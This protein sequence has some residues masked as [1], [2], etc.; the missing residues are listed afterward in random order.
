MVLP[1]D[2]VVDLKDV[3][4]DDKHHVGDRAANLGSLACK[5]SVPQGFIVAYPAYFEFLSHDNLG[6]KIKHL[7]GAINFDFPESVGHVSSHIRRII[8]SSKISDKIVRAVMESYEKLGSPRVLVQ[9][10]IISGNTDQDAF[11]RE[12]STYNVYGEASLLDVLR[13]SWASIF[14]PEL[15]LHR[16]KNGVDHLKTS[17]SALATKLIQPATYGKILTGD[18]HF[19]DTSKIIIQISSDYNEYAVD[20]KDSSIRKRPKSV[21]D[22]P[23]VFVRNSKS[24]PPSLQNDEIIALAKLGDAIEKH[25]YFPQAIDWAKEKDTTY[26]LNASKLTF[27]G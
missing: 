20:R 4:L 3:D 8:N 9:T 12:Y 10:T 2:I 23:R 6:F 17:V 14:S 7:L 16:H 11:E 1:N 27:N 18:P 19:S 26:V 13:S 22:G 15:I 21:S 5:F 24:A 25:F